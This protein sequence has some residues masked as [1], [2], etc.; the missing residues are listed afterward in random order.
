MNSKA[1]LKKV[2]VIAVVFQLALGQALFAATTN[3]NFTLDDNDVDSPMVIMKDEGENIFTL[4]KLDGGAAVL[5]NNEGSIDFKPSADVDDYLQMLTT[6]NLPSI[7][8]VGAASTFAPGIRISVGD[9]TGQLQY[10]DEN[11][12]TW[13]SFD[14]MRGIIPNDSTNALD[15]KDD[16]GP[17]NNYLNIDTT[18]ETMAFG[19]IDTNPD[20]TFLGTGTLTIPNVNPPVLGGAGQIA[21][22]TGVGAGSDNALVSHNGTNQYVLANEIKEVTFTITTD[23]DWSDDVVPV[24]RTPKS[25]TI[26]IIESTGSVLGAGAGDTVTCGVTYGSTPFAATTGTDALTSTAAD[27]AGISMGTSTVPENQYLVFSSTAESG[28]VT[29]VTIHIRYRVNN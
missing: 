8:W 15:I 7:M 4:Q 23:G 2:V 21:I 17:P 3:K 1:V 20:Y 28:T 16:A 10:R 29:A 6:L 27:R 11:S 9:D 13:V 18:G 19:N 25:S 24:W 5:F 14:S 12:D 26:D 22:D